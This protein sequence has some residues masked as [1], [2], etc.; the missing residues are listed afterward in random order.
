MSR[1]TIFTL[2]LLGGFGIAVLIELIYLLG[3]RP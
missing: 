2:F 1:F 3:V